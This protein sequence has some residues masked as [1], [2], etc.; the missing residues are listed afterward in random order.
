M[1]GTN[2][3]VNIASVDITTTKP[4]PFKIPFHDATMGPFDSI[5]LSV[6]SITDT[7]G[8]KEEV[9]INTSTIPYLENILIPVLLSLKDDPYQNAINI[10]FWSIRNEGFRGNASV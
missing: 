1:L 6:L 7:E 8:K 9:P 5:S 3:I 10:L 2:E 4:N